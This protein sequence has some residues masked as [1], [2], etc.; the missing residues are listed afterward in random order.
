MKNKEYLTEENSCFVILTNHL[1]E[2]LCRHYKFP[3]VRPFPGLRGP[4]ILAGAFIKFFSCEEG[5]SFEGGVHL[6]RDPLSDN[7]GLL[8]QA[9]TP[10]LTLNVI[11]NIHLK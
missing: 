8:I 3:N 11:L 10:Q 2:R 9:A 6:G 7:Y 4:L 5:R 1:N